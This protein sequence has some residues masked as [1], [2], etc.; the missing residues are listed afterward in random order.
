LQSGLD[1]PNRLKFD[2]LSLEVADRA[3]NEIAFK[4]FLKLSEER[5]DAG[6]K[7]ATTKGPRFAILKE[8][9]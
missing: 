7:E 2:G 3:I 6:I 1:A 5:T 9:A 4:V 8:R